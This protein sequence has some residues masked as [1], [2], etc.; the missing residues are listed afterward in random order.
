MLVVSHFHQQFM[1]A[2]RGYDWVA[3]IAGHTNPSTTVHY[4]RQTMAQRRLAPMPTNECVESVKCSGNGSTRSISNRATRCL[5][6][7]KELCNLIVRRRRIGR[8]S[9]QGGV[10]HMNRDCPISGDCPNDNLWSGSSIRCLVYS[11][12]KLIA[13][14]ISQCVERTGGDCHKANLCRLHFVLYR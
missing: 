11:S 5:C 7:S 10:R 4:A 8:R 12:S 6:R 1:G 9:G 13:Y 3:R 2:G 14:S